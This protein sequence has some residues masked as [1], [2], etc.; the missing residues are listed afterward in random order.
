[1]LFFARQCLPEGEDGQLGQLEVLQPEG[2]AD[3][4]DA[5]EAAYDEVG[6][7]QFD[8]AEDNPDD[9]EHKV[10]ASHGYGVEYRSLAK[11]PHGIDTNLHQLIAEG[12]ADEGDAIEYSEQDVGRS[13]EKSAQYKPKNVS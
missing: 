7:G 9:V 10:D 4:G 13:Q 11:R 8:A 1:L 2:D 3:D 12:N 6:N 5:E